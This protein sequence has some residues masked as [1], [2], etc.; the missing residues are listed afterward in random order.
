LDS[1]IHDL[2]ITFSLFRALRGTFLLKGVNIY[3]VS[4][5]LTGNGDIL[6]FASSAA[7]VIRESTID[8]IDFSLS[9]TLTSCLTKKQSVFSTIEST[10]QFYDTVI[11]NVKSKDHLFEWI[12]STGI[13]LNNVTIFNSETLNKLQMMSFSKSKVTRISHSNFTQNQKITFL[14]SKTTI[15]EFDANVLDGRNRGIRLI[16]NSNAT[17]SNSVF[18]NMQQLVKEGNISVSELNHSGAAIR[19]YHAYLL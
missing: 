14:F 19:K 4:K 10:A 12:I 3:N 8:S 15:S 1:E 6:E 11:S 16:D 18:K 2:I 9:W 5:D 13:I 7:A 17:I